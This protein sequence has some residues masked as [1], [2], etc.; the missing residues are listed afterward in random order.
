M[1]LFSAIWIGVARSIN[2]KNAAS[3]RKKARLKAFDETGKVLEKA[4]KKKTFVNG[5]KVYRAK[6]RIELRRIRIQ[7]NRIDKF[8]DDL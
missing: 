7:Q 4:K 6:L 2:D 5:S 8:I 3:Q 1:G